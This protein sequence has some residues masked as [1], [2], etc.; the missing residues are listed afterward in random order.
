MQYKIGLVG[1]GVMGRNLALNIERNGFPIAVWNRNPQ[2]MHDFIS[3]EGEGKALLGVEKLPDLMAALEKPRRVILMVQAGAAVDEVIDQIKPLM[4][5]GD[6]LIDCGNTFFTD[7]ER[8]NKALEAEGFQYIGAGVSGGE[9]GAKWGPAIMP[10]GNRP[11]WEALSEIFYAIAAKAEDGQPCVEYM[12]PGGAGHYVKMVHNGIEYGDMQLISE[13]YDL[14]SRGLGLGADELHAIFSRWNEGLLKSY[15]I[16]ITA[17]IFKTIDPDT[18]LPLVDLI[19]DQAGQKGTGKWTSQNALDIGV[20]VPTINAALQGRIISS[21]KEERVYAATQLPSPEQKYEGDA[22]ELI[23]A[24]ENALY[25]SKV[26][27][28][29]QGLA[30]L[31]MASLEYNYDLNIRDV[32]KIWRSGCI[33]RASLLGDIMAAYERDPQLVNLMLD[34]VFKSAILE[35]LDDWRKVVQIA[36]GLGIPV[37]AMSGALSYFDAYRSEHL[38]ANLI[39]AQ[40]DYFGAHTYRRIDKDGVFHTQWV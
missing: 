39:Q 36:V 37:P 20:P 10:G 12:G 3:E 29:A 13:A 28:Y 30:M 8:R 19:L 9:E 34:E 4:D 23:N 1:L 35:R 22:A 38:P 2:R 33:I 32:A 17:D 24:I 5:P 15:L 25:A 11:A 18:G 21:L 40:R 16:E 7:T 26:T 31:R 27:S 6:I 14:L